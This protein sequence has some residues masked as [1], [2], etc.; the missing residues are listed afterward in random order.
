MRADQIAATRH[1][2]GIDA[3]EVPADLRRGIVEVQHLIE[4]R[5]VG[6]RRHL[7]R[8]M[9]WLCRRLRFRGAGERLVD[10]AERLGKPPNDV[11][12]VTGEPQSDVDELA[13]PGL[14]AA[15]HRLPAV[16]RVESGAVRQ[17]FEQCRALFGDVGELLEQRRVV[18]EQQRC[19]LVE[20]VASGRRISRYQMLVLRRE[21][22]GR[23]ESDQIAHVL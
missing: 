21:R 5:L 18:G 3:L 1:F 11:R 4:G 16:F 13:G 17:L 10:A 23:D 7:L 20:E 14:Q 12:A 2:S 6:E 8:R 19:R 15:Q 9:R 22:H